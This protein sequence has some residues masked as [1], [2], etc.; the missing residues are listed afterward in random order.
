M[1]ITGNLHCLAVQSICICTRKYYFL[2]VLVFV[3]FHLRLSLQLCHIRMKKML[4]FCGRTYT[5]KAPTAAQI[6]LCVLLGV[7]ICLHSDAAIDGQRREAHKT[8]DKQ[9][10][11]PIL[12]AGNDVLGPRIEK[13]LDDTQV[14]K[15]AN[16]C[17]LCYVIC[18]CFLCIACIRS[19]SSTLPLQWAISHLQGLSESG[20]YETLRLKQVIAAAKQVWS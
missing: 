13:N 9:Q 8:Q 5:S 14:L 6:M 1:S 16:V 3:S 4:S 15:A 2:C 19:F 11:E 17:T 10:Q 7:T 18:F 12:D 20:I